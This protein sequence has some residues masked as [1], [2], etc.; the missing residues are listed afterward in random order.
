MGDNN[1]WMTSNLKLT[2][3]GSYYY[4]D[5]VKYDE[6]Y[7]RLYTWEAAQTGCGYLGK[8]WR[9]PTKEDWLRLAENYGAIGREESNIEKRAF[10]PLLTGGNSQF[11]AVLGGGR[12][13]DGS[14]ARMDAHGFYWTITQHDS[15]TAW[16][17]N[18]ARGTQA[19]YI[20]PEGEK[21]RAF[22]VRCIK[23]TQGLKK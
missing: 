18:F 22:S 20:Q 21:V 1:L 10:S 15:A 23:S 16:F 5:S 2:I 9:L 8:G 17:G 11:D 6:Q 14:Y 7:G 19:L 12:N 13:P 3:Q 4:N